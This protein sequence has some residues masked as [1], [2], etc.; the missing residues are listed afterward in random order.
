M[1]KDRARRAARAELA[2]REA[3]L[4]ND[5]LARPGLYASGFDDTALADLVAEYN[6]S[7]RE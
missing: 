1:L 4:A 6:A 5:P 7:L 3:A 2:E